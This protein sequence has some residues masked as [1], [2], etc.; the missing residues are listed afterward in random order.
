MAKKAA[1]KTDDPRKARHAALALMQPRFTALSD[2]ALPQ[3]EAWRDSFE[4][5]SHL[6]PVY[7]TLPKTVTPMAVAVYGDWGTGKTTA[8]RWL[9]SLLDTWNRQ[10]KAK[11]K[12][13]VEPV[14]F[15]PWKYHA[16]EDVWRG[17]IAEVILSSIQV[18]GAT[19]AQVTKAA[20]QFGLFLGRSFLHALAAVKV[21]AEAPGG[22]VGA[23]LSLSAVRDIVEEFREA[24]HPEKAYL[25]EFEQTLKDWVGDTITKGHRLVLFIDDLDRCMPDVALEVLEALKLY[26]NIPNI[27][28]V[29]GV[30]R[31]VVDELV[32]THYE[33]LGLAKDKSKH[34]LA[35]MFQIEVTLTVH[36][37]QIEQFLDDQLAAFDLW[38]ELS[39]D[40]QGI[41]RDRILNLAA[42]NPRE[43]KR[44]INSALMYGAGAIMAQEL[45]NG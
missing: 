9:D 2:R 15:Y 4:L 39:G 24:A 45:E 7:D 19:M 3:E 32:Q 25:N 11:D 8:M 6:G 22:V 23:E 30:D 27:I 43:V 21:K 41:F 33:R 36:E 18:K 5:A 31:N 14:W 1:K 26:L 44:L 42:R 20:K 34:Y 38:R 28:F 13:T 10:G 40:H 35:K 12:V 29:V 16:R 17:L 37:G